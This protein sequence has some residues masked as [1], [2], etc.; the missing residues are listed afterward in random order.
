MPVVLT[1]KVHLAVNVKLGFQAMDLK[2]VQVGLTS[3]LGVS[4]LLLRADVFLNVLYYDFIDIDE[5]SSNPCHSNANCT[6][7]E[8]SFDCQCNSGFSGDGYNCTSNA[9]SHI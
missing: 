4:Y 3:I 5:C 7:N 9:R 8:G 1:V 6:D 2:I